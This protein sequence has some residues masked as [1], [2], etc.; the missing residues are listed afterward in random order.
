MQLIQGNG[1]N[2]FN[3]ESEFSENV[4]RFALNKGSPTDERHLPG[5]VRDNHFGMFCRCWIRSDV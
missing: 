4:F 3:W 2:R 5:Q 1:V